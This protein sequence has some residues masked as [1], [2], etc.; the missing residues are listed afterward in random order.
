MTMIAPNSHAPWK[1][2]V[3]EKRKEEA[4]KGNL[5]GTLPLEADVP[6]EKS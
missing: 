4:K 2:G 3:Q 5:K 1:K 6:D